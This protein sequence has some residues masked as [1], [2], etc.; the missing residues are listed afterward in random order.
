MATAS[1]KPLWVQIM[2][3]T[4]RLV[5]MPTSSM[6]MTSSGLVMASTRLPFSSRLMR[7]EPAADD[8]VARQQPEGGRLRGGLREVDDADV[9]LAG[10]GGDDV[11]LGDEALRHEQVAEAAAA[12]VLAGERGVRAAR[13]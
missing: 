12:V 1:S 7:D 10:D 9:H 5:R 11:L 3:T 2:G 13:E 4:R 8:E 6:E